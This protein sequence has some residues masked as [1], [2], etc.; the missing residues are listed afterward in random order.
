MDIV[1]GTR[2]EL[3]ISWVLPQIDALTRAHP[4]VQFHLYFGSGSDLVLRVRTME[5]DCAITSSRF[6]DRRLDSVRLHREDSVFVGAGSL[7]A[8]NPFTRVSHAQNHVLL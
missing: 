4:Q 5:I 6:T 7:L 8:K 3:G 1:L 2:H